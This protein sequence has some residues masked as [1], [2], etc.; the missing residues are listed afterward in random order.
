MFTELKGRE[1]H[2]RVILIYGP[3]RKGA[4]ENIY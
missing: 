4:I 3:W 1:Y 2:E